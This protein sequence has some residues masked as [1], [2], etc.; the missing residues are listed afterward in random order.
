MGKTSL[1]TKLKKWGIYGLFAFLTGAGG[2]G[3]WKACQL[4]YSWYQGDKQAAIAD[5]KRIDQLNQ[6][7]KD[8]EGVNKSIEKTNERLSKIDA[9][10]SSIEG[11]VDAVLMLLQGQ[12]TDRNVA[13]HRE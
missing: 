10:T 12:K 13:M 1:K 11:K 8:I 7:T 3:C 5:A 9:R 4:G 6:N 2:A